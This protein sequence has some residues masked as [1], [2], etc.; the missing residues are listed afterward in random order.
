MPAARPMPRVAP[1]QAMQAHARRA[2]LRWA[3]ALLA[4]LLLAGH[5]SAAGDDAWTF[6]PEVLLARSEQAIGN[7][8]DAAIDRL[9]QAVWRSAQAPAEMAAMCAFFAPDARRDLA[10]INRAAARFSPA[11]QR[12]FQQATDG[13]L[14]SAQQAPPQPYAPDLAMHALK[15]AAVTAAMLHDGF[16]AGISASGSDAASQRARCRSLRLLLGTVSMRPPEERAM[17]TRL[18][19][20]EGLRRLQR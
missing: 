18:L 9:F 6:D 2:S 5:A 11:S 3:G 14:R 12:R 16:I 4:W 8:S 13:L 7:A 20:R 19:M 10:A 1:M 17:I 15:Q